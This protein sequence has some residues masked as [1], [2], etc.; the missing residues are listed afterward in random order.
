MKQPIH[1]VR[2]GDDISFFKLQQAANEKVLELPSSKEE[3]EGLIRESM[4]LRDAHRETLA[5][6]ELGLAKDLVAELKRK[7]RRYL[8]LLQVRRSQQAAAVA[9]FRAASAHSLVTPKTPQTEP[10]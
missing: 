10:R 2:P 6:I 5:A 8:K 4:L 7:A 9:A 3:Y 1:V